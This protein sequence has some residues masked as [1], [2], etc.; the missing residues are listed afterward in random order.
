MAYGLCRGGR[1]D[2]PVGVQSADDL[3]GRRL[4]RDHRATSPRSRAVHK[5]KG[6]TIGYIYLDAPYGKEPI[7]LL[8]ELAKENGFK[9][10]KYPV[11]GAD[12]GISRRS[13]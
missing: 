13:G 8:E 11:P 1:Q 6:K 9:L 2:L 3:L 12:A 10:A 4:G 5:L 7:P